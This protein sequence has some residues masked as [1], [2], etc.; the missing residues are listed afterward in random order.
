M[1][2]LERI[3]DPVDC[4][5]ILADHVDLVKK[6]R[7]CLNALSNNGLIPRFGSPRLRVLVFVLSMNEL[8]P[9]ENPTFHMITK[10]VSDLG[11]SR[12]EMKDIVQNLCS[13]GFVERVGRY[14]YKV[15]EKM[16][17]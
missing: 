13:Y 10:A 6:I 15:V 9:C 12:K 5:V 17:V 1:R 4:S 7:R 16:F 2:I 14:R 3:L 11:I 8:Q